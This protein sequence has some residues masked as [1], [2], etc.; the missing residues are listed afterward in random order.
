MASTNRSFI[1]AACV[2]AGAA[3]LHAPSAPAQYKWIGPDGRV[4]YSDLP[5]PP[6][7][8][9][10]L[11]APGAATAAGDAARGDAARGDAARGDA[12]G[13]DAGRG[14]DGSAQADGGPR[15]PHALRTAVDRHPVMLYTT[16]SC[17]PCDLARAH[18]MQRGVPYTEKRVRSQAD[19]Q[20]FEGLGFESAQFPSVSVGRDRMVG[21]EPSAWTRML[22]AAG[23]PKSSQ[24][25]SSYAG[26]PVEDLQ[27]VTR[28]ASARASGAAGAPAA[29]AAAESAGQASAAPERLERE[30]LLLPATY[31][32]PNN[33][34]RF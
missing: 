9:T 16:P 2:A 34:I 32:A 23:Y 15:L 12:A 17:D 26:R 28:A 3:L 20:A 33:P 7:H 6:D 30:T 27:P 11:R 29:G 25:P 21:F 31:D 22:D 24:L 8:R 4:N 18:L 13:D 14:R 10:L 1:I 19:A 5:P